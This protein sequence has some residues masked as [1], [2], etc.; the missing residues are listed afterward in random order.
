V[1]LE[2][3]GASAV[4][5]ESEGASVVELESEDPSVVGLE[6][7]AESPVPPLPAS[8]GPPASASWHTP[9]MHAPPVHAVPLLSGVHCDVE[10]DG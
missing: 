5:L 9:A 1:E 6:S 8:V 4:E 2:S 10:V 3:E 7:G